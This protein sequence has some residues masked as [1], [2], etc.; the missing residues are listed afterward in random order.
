M[1]QIRQ[2]RFKLA[3]GHPAL[4]FINT[5]RDWT[6]PEP[7]DYLGDFADAIRFGADYLVVGRPILRASNP[8]A[9]ADDVIREIDAALRSRVGE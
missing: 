6:V 4:D 1:A 7:Q 8:R 3:G 2:H 9:A 5:V